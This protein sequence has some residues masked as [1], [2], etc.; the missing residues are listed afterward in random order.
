MGVVYDAADFAEGLSRCL[1]RMSVTKG[2]KSSIDLNHVVLNITKNTPEIAVRI[3]EL[4]FQNTSPEDIPKSRAHKSW[5]AYLCLS[6]V[7]EQKID[8]DDCVRDLKKLEKCLRSLKRQSESHPRK[9][10]EERWLRAIEQLSDCDA[11][12]DEKGKQKIYC[13]WSR[14]MPRTVQQ[15]LKFSFEKIFPKRISKR[16]PF[17]RAVRDLSYTLSRKSW[18]QRFANELCQFC[19]IHEDGLKKLEKVSAIAARDRSAVAKLVAEFN[20]YLQV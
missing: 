8:Y 15:K 14:K 3:F 10:E 12:T 9:T 18:G 19:M 6:M 11:I 4:S 13:R 1:V 5:H 2:R 16:S 17:H 20:R 7:K